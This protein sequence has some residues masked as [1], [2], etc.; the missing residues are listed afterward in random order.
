VPTIIEM[1]GHTRLDCVIGSAAG[2]RVGVVNATH[3]AAHRQ[4]FGKTLIDQPLMRN[5]LADL[6]LE[7]EATTALAMRLARAYDEAHADAQAG[8]ND[9]D[10]QL[11]KRLATAVGK[12]WTCKRAPN[13]AFESLECLGGNGYVEESGMPRLYREAPLASIWEGSGNVMSLD[14]L[15]ALTRAPR[16]LEVF[17]GELRE[18]QGA[19]PRLDARVRELEGQFAD[20]STLE[21]R[22]R[23]VVES[24]AL[25]LQGSLLVR[26]GPSAVADAFCASRLA[27]DGGLEYGTLP[28]GSDFEAIIARGLP[29][30]S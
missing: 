3:H 11:F 13:H 16:A 5:V 25:C 21:T 8:E 28:A 23:R 29:Q 30:P 6:C 4:A 2:M 12:Y 9:T 1:V 19:D 7:S 26:H 18:A 24:M 20:P 10:A 14:V 27:G 15:R 22:A 17:L